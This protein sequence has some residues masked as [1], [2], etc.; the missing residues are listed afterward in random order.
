MSIRPPRHLVSLPLI[1]G[2]LLVAVGVQADDNNNPSEVEQDSERPVIV[3][4]GEDDELVA[5]VAAELR[6]AGFEVLVL[7]AESDPHPSATNVNIERVGDSVIVHAA[8]PDGKLEAELMEPKNADGLTDRDA[9]ALR[10]A[11]AIRSLATTPAKVVTAQ[12][13]AAEPPTAPAAVIA[14]PTPASVSPDPP[15]VPAATTWSGQDTVQHEVHEMPVVRLALFAGAGYLAPEP[16]LVGGVSLRGQITPKFNIAGLLMGSKNIDHDD[17]HD[18]DLELY[19]ARAALLA[20]WEILGA[21]HLWTPSIGGGMFAELRYWRFAGFRSLDEPPPRDDILLSASSVG[22][23]EGAMA[24]GG[25]AATAGISVAHPWRF[26]FDIHADVRMIDVQLD[27]AGH[28]EMAPELAPS[29]MATVGIEYD[30]ITRPVLTHTA[31]R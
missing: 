1:A 28:D 18:T 21:D 2:L 29:V 24:S 16:A 4:S 22:L 9:T 5:S 10:T 17:H 3:I 14:E 31:R 26:R 13:A 7:P 15:P 19:S 23:T 20:S 25:L 11:E 6:A 27:G 30:F 8:R 12:P